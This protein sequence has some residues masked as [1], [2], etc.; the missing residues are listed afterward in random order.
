[1]EYALAP[2]LAKVKALELIKAVSVEA[3]DKKAQSDKQKRAAAKGEKENQRRLQ[4]AGRAQVRRPADA[5]YFSECD[6]D[7]DSD[8]E[9]EVDDGV[10]DSGVFRMLSSWLCFA[11]CSI[12]CTLTSSGCLLYVVVRWFPIQ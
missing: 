7:Y 9:Y 8:D 12:L 3:A 10:S 11:S 4:V 2:R 1:M 6:D 5:G